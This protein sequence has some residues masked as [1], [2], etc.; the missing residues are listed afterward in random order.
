MFSLSKRSDHFF[1]WNCVNDEWVGF[2]LYCSFEVKIDLKRVGYIIR[3]KRRRKSHETVLGLKLK[4]SSKERQ[5]G[6]ISFDRLSGYF[7]LI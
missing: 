2:C 5:S 7:S 4:V 3:P 6:D 1:F